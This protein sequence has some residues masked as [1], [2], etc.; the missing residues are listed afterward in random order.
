MDK[1]YFNLLSNAFK[2]TPDNGKI[3]ITIQEKGNQAVISFK[4]NGIGIP[5]KRSATFSNPILKVPTTGKTVQESGFISAVS[6]WSFI[7][8]NRGQS[9]QGTEFIISLY[10]GNKHFNED[11]M[12]KEPVLWMR[13]RWQ[14]KMFLARWKKEVLC[15]TRKIDRYSLLL[16]EDNSI[17]HFSSAISFRRNLM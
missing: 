1:V 7:S 11:Q 15:K 16:V 3:E 17:C 5:K 10:K 4:D 8:E 6:L 14:K 9:F 12:I 13:K 2:F